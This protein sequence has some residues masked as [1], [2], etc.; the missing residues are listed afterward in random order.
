MCHSAGRNFYYFFTITN[1]VVF[2]EIQRRHKA[3]QF[4]LVSD[5]STPLFSPLQKNKK[6]NFVFWTWGRLYIRGRW[7]KWNV[8]N[9]NW[10]NEIITSVKVLSNQGMY[11]RISILICSSEIFRFY[12]SWLSHKWLFLYSNWWFLLEIQLV[13]L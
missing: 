7:N 12:G 13:Y 9:T 11:F 1:S 10:I 5:C 2:N 4:E 8:T 6:P 3:K